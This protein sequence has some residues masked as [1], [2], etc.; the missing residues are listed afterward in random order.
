MVSSCKR[1]NIAGCAQ[2]IITD[3]ASI[4]ER[5]RMAARSARSSRSTEPKQP[6]GRLIGPPES[7]Q[8][9]FPPKVAHLHRT[10]GPAQLRLLPADPDIP[11]SS[12]DRQQSPKLSRFNLR[13]RGMNQRPK[14]GRPKK[15]T[16]VAIWVISA[17]RCRAVP[18]KVGVSVGNSQSGERTSVHHDAARSAVTMM[19]KSKVLHQRQDRNNAYAQLSATI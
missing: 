13:S 19:Q 6:A 15:P 4:A 18:P 10:I 5:A 2:S 3:G 14:L 7:G 8:A 9:G 11:G 16:S 1:L 17:P 12:G